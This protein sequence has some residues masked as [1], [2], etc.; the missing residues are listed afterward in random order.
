MAL[1]WGN[2]DVSWFLEAV[3]CSE[4]LWDAVGCCRMLWDALGCRGMLKNGF[5]SHFEVI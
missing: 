4:I 1:L 5:Q 2:R 3:G